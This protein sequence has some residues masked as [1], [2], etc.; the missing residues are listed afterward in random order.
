MRSMLIVPRN[1]SAARSTLPASAARQAHAAAA[2]QRR[3][4][5]G[6]LPSGGVASW[7]LGVRR[8]LGRAGEHRSVGQHQEVGARAR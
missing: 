3:F 7:G 2:A 4:S 1:S 5:F 8:P 6:G